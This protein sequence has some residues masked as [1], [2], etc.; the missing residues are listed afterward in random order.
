M[1]RTVEQLRLSV[2]EDAVHARNGEFLIRRMSFLK[3]AETWAETEERRR[4]FWNVFLMDRFCSIATGYV[5]PFL[6]KIIC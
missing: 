4:V 3:R 5:F 6:L 2:E 1:T